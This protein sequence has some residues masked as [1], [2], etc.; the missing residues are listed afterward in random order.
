MGVEVLEYEIPSDVTKRRKQDVRSSIEGVTGSKDGPDS[1]F[2]ADLIMLLEGAPTG[3]EDMLFGTPDQQ[4]IERNPFCPQYAAALSGL[5]RISAHLSA[6]ALPSKLPSISQTSSSSTPSIPPAI[7]PA[8]P[9]RIATTTPIVSTAS[10]V[11]I[12]KPEVISTSFAI[13]PTTITQ[14][15]TERA[16]ETATAP[17]A[18]IQINLVDSKEKL[19]ALITQRQQAVSIATE[20][21][22]ASLSKVASLDTRV[23]SLVSQY[24]TVSSQAATAIAQVKTIAQAQ[25]VPLPEV[26]KQ[27]PGII[28]PALKLQAQAQ[29][30]SAQVKAVDAV[31]SVEADKA[32][33]FTKTAELGKQMASNASTQ[34]NLITKAEEAKSVG[35][36]PA[37]KDLAIQAVKVGEKTAALKTEREKQIIDWTVKGE[38]DKVLILD[39]TRKVEEAKIPLLEKSSLPEPVK[40]EYIQKVVLNVQK[41]QE[42]VKNT[43][44]NLI[45]AG[46]SKV[47]YTGT[48]AEDISRRA[49]FWNWVNALE[50]NLVD[51]AIF[52]I[53]GDF[54][55]T[56]AQ[57]LKSDMTITSVPTNVY[58]KV[59]KAIER[60][61]KKKAKFSLGG[62]EV[63]RISYDSGGWRICPSG[64]T[65]NTVLSPDMSP[66]EIGKT[67]PPPWPVCRAKTDAEKAATT[68]EAILAAQIAAT[69][70]AARK[71]VEA[72]LVKSLVIHGLV[73]NPK[74][75]V[76]FQKVKDKAWKTS[77]GESQQYAMIEAR[78]R[79]YWPQNPKKLAYRYQEPKIDTLDAYW[80]IERFENVLSTPY[81]W[82]HSDGTIV[83]FGDTTNI[84]AK[85]WNPVRGTMI[86]SYEPKNG[87]MPLMGYYVRPQTIGDFFD[88]IE[89]LFN[90]VIC[91]YGQ[92]LLKTIPGSETVSDSLDWICS[93]AAKKEI[94]TFFDPTKDETKKDETK[95]DETSTSSTSTATKVAA[96]VGI[97]AVLLWLAL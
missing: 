44:D 47:A 16:F 35:N 28:E 23:T 2:G 77:G 10:S 63:A 8:L 13:K 33:Q 38:A 5:E 46:Y 96:G 87:T 79:L 60:T 29:V 20:G 71:A 12:S 41:I 34:L 86:I 49:A 61:S 92:P 82:K 90:T 91:P 58:D 1:H 78:Y 21:A 88:D 89:E 53:G 70:V 9:P 43:A 15:M 64:Q 85:Y 75:Q 62:L 37:A 22:K 54:A 57:A 26:A 69:R 80:I 30:L 11:A 4:A 19:A 68:P 42:E 81:I 94:T 73:L 32:V 51:D 56:L 74:E 95:K 93:G 83:T 50:T 3:L 39:S 27:L 65:R 67:E 76:A 17:N 24:S 97:A 55:K 52:S 84:W 31:R 72:P 45:A 48:T 25:G 18:P 66:D 6:M 7:K 59:M 14:S 40:Q 36:L